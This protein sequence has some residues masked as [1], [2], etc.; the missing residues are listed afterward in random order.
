M[1]AAARAACALLLSKGCCLHHCCPPA[2][3]PPCRLVLIRRLIHGLAFPD[4]IR[5]LPDGQNTVRGLSTIDRA[6]AVTYNQTRDWIMHNF[7]LDEDIA[8]T[9]MSMVDFQS[10]QLVDGNLGC[11]AIIPKW[12][13]DPKMWKNEPIFMPK[14]MPGSSHKLPTAATL[15]AAKKSVA[16]IAK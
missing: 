15:K 7:N 9:V 16:K 14:V 4:Y 1:R 13:F 3:S 11:H 12:I 5:E 6:M 10:T 8:I 2:H